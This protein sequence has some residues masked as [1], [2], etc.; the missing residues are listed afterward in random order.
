VALPPAY[1]IAMSVG[2]LNFGTGATTN[3]YGPD[4]GYRNVITDIQVTPLAPESGG[5][6]YT[7]CFWSIVDPDENTL[8][9]VSGPFDIGQTIP[10]SGRIVLMETV[11]GLYVIS[12]AGG[13]FS[14]AISG[15]KLQ[16]A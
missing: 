15:F 5:A 3:F 7:L 13:T 16:V 10:W 14:W 9:S 8:Y 4:S 11:G 2:N 12:A 6:E 1:S